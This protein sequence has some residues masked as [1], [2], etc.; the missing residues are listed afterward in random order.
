MGVVQ[1]GHKP[2]NAV[3][4]SVNVPQRRPSLWTVAEEGCQRNTKNKE[5]TPLLTPKSFRLKEQVSY[6]GKH[7]IDPHN[8]AKRHRRECKHCVT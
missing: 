2:L 3:H 4:R 1:I 6:M 8:A 5:N 7:H